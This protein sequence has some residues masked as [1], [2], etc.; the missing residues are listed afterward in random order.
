MMLE[1]ANPIRVV[2]TSGEDGYAIYVTTG[3]VFDNDIWC[4]ALCDGGHIR[5]FRSD[6]IKMHTNATLDIVKKPTA[7]ITSGI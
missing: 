4:V 7:K 5:H 2:T 1:F 6:Q 3:G